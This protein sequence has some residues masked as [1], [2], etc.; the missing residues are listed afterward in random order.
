MNNNEPEFKLPGKIKGFLPVLA[1]QYA[2]TRQPDLQEVIINAEIRVEKARDIETDFGCAYGFSIHLIIPEILFTRVA[3][4]KNK[5]EK[6]IEESMRGLYD[7]QNEHV[8]R[9]FLEIKEDENQDWRKKSGLL[10]SGKRFVLPESE[11]RIWGDSGYRL[12]LSHKSEVKAEVAKLKEDLA[13]YG[14]SCF[15][16]HEDIKP[17]KE[18]QLEIENALDSMD[19]LAAI[20]IADFHTSDWT[21]QEVG[22]AIGRG[23]PIVPVKLEQDPCG[24]IEKLQALPCTWETAAKG[25]S[26]ILINQGKMVDAYV[27]AVNKCSTFNSANKLADILPAFESITPQQVTALIVAF[28]TNNQIHC[29]FG[30]NGVYGNGLAHHLNRLTKKNYTIT[31][32]EKSWSIHET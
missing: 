1:S 11:K 17:T 3:G 32:D 10:L 18:W 22:V 2:A 25:I 7:L 23:V 30:F 20:L 29:S 9:V 27:D 4:M 12:F 28:N 21:D 24:F 5:I 6:R 26:K 8:D 13:F 15:V 31:Q 16:A 14:I 19:A